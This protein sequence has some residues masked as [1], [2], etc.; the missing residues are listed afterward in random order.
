[1]EHTMFVSNTNRLIHNK[2]KRELLSL[3]EKIKQKA[4][5]SYSLNLPHPLPYPADLIGMPLEK[6]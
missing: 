4:Q 6:A 1:M 5:F 3:N 2:G